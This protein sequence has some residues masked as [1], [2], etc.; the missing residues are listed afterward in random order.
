MSNTKIR[1][2]MIL[3]GGE[4][5]RL[6]PLTYILP[7][8]LVYVVNRPSIEYIIKFLYNFGIREFAIN[9][10]YKAELMEE[11]VENRFKKEFK[12]CS[13]YILKEKHL[14]GTAGPVKKLQDFFNNENFIVIGC[15]DIFDF[16][17][18][19]IIETHLK[20]EN[21]ATIALYKVN[22]PSQFGV[23]IIDENNN[24]I[25][26]QEKPKENPI[27]YLA[28]TGV[29]I[30]SPK[31]FDYILSKTY[32]DFGTQVFFNLIKEKAKFQGIDITNKPLYLKY[33]YWIDIGNINSYFEAN[34]KL[35]ELKHPFINSRIIKTINS[36]LVLGDNVEINS[37]T[38]VEGFAIIGD[39]SKIS[40]YISN[41]II[42]PNN[43]LYNCYLKNSIITS[44]NN[45]KNI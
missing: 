6:R 30:F 20:N 40:G 26:F 17:L 1:K 7:K 3:A 2:A 15:D 38:I 10:S 19:Y 34:K 28:N 36:T 23:A 14:S 44:T 18:N 37:N 8:P 29:Y 12:D 22:D 25:N 33:S 5:T 41:S 9:I 32:Y 4:G 27:S 21:I 42:W 24:I 45:I 11:Y 35:I 16:D 13:L 39:N 43:S 31:I